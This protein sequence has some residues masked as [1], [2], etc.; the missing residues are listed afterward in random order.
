[1]RIGIAFKTRNNQAWMVML[2][3]LLL[4]SCVNHRKVSLIRESD[5]SVDIFNIENPRETSYRIQTG[6]QLYVKVHSLDPQT[7]RF[8]QTEF[9]NLMNPTY[10]Y[11][12]S[13]TV[14][15]EGFISFSFIE[16]LHV[17]GKTLQETQKELQQALNEYFKEANVIVKLV[18]FQITLIGEVRSPGT[19]TI[20]REY[21]NVLQAIGLAGGVSEFANINRVKLV[22]QTAAGS[23]V[24]ILDLSEIDMLAQD[25][26]H[27][28]PN[29]VIYIDSRPVKSFT[30]RAVPYGLFLSL[31][32]TALVIYSV[33]VE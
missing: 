4:S 25:S 31:F 33:F 28:M 12:N 9:P 3:I 17:Q 23:V 16:K 22:R 24:K 5:E 20:Q 19:Y 14:D 29:D 10:L 6:D 15:E 30:Q 11:L 21:A 13:Y 2:A 8:F 1:M 27:L 32:S 18:N 7:S 26:Y